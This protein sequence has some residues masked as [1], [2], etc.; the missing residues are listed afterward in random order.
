VLRRFGTWYKTLDRAALRHKERRL[1]EDEMRRDLERVARLLDRLPSRGDYRQHG[2]FADR[3]LSRAVEGGKWEQVLIRLL[4]LSTAEAKQPSRPS[5]RSDEDRLEELRQLRAKLKR[6]PG[7]QEAAEHGIVQ[8]VLIKRFGSWQAVCAAAE[9]PPPR[10]KGQ[11]ARYTSDGELIEDIAATARSLG[12]LPTTTE[13]D[14]L[15]RFKSTAIAWR[16]G[17]WRA[18]LR[19]ERLKNFAPARRSWTRRKAGGGD[20]T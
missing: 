10:L 5:F 13:Q 4:G 8:Q 17:T 19:H 12:R 15:G 3:T 2:S 16:F 20:E 7:V 1:S 6:T 18:A 14:R 9:L 11:R